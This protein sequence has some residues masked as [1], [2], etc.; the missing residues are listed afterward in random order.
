MELHGGALTASS[1]GH[2]RGAELVVTLPLLDA[3]RG[4][5]DAQ[6]ETRHAP[7]EGLRLLVI[8]DDPGTRAMLQVSLRQFGAEVTAAGTAADAF[9]QLTAQP[10]DVVVSDIGLPGEDGYSLIRRM[11]AGAARDIPAIALTAYAAAGERERA[12]EAGFDAWLA[13][14]IDPASLAEEVR[15]TARR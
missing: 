6:R 3:A 1:E 11:R 7:L 2:G 8:E 14:P 10:F 9:A 12:L 4:A 13:K 5:A 15:R